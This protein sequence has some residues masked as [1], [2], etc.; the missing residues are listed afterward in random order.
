MFNTEFRYNNV[1]GKQFR[2]I[3]DVTF[4]KVEAVKIDLWKSQSL[5]CFVIWNNYSSLNVLQYKNFSATKWYSS[6]GCAQHHNK[7]QLA[8]RSRWSAKPLQKSTN[9]K[10]IQL[11]CE[12][13][14]TNTT[15]K[16]VKNSEGRQTLAKVDISIGNNCIRFLIITENINRFYGVKK[17]WICYRYNNRVNLYDTIAKRPYTERGYCIS[18]K[19]VLE[20]SI[21]G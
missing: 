20:I 13:K 4:R 21:Y 14:K 19:M 8:L 17:P 18:G 3:V 9:W 12:K 16:M 6:N 11:L 10:C 15:F 2:F 7:M 5:V 1:F